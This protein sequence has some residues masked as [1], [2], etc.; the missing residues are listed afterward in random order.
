MREK[1]QKK[2]QKKHAREIDGVRYEYISVQEKQ[3]FGIEKIWMDENF[4]VSITDKE[5]TLL[6]VFIFSKMFGGMGEALGVLENALG[7]I[8]IKELVGYALKYNK[9]SVIKRLGWALEYFGVSADYFT[10]LLN[11]PMNYYCRLD[12][13]KPAVGPC[14]KRWMI[15][16]NLLK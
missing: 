11:V 13:S 1:Y 15:Q 16:N 8:D 3:Y 14:D 4:Q 5:R 6:D 9:K 12:P 7:E 10:P 2:M